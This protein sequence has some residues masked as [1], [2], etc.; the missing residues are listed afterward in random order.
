MPTDLAAA[1]SDRYGLRSVLG[2][3]GMATVY[4]GFD[5]KH[6]RE[7]AIKVLRGEIASTIGADRFLAEIRIVARLV[8][9]NI[10][11]LHDSGE[12]GGFIYYVM[13]Y[14]DGGSLRDRLLRDRRMPADRAIAIAE[15]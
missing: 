10:L 4:M 1:L 7:V 8:H 12:S 2:R 13:P 11:S 9:P 14:I 3:G 15:P 5:R 6:E